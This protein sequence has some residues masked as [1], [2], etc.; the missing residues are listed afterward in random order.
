MLELLYLVASFW[1]PAEKS[2]QT[3]YSKNFSKYAILITQFYI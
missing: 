3:V 1:R 2:N